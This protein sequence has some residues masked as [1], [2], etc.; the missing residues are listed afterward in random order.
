MDN[1]KI[2]E[3]GDKLNVNSPDI[4]SR[5]SQHWFKKHSFWMMHAT[6]FVLSGLMGLIFS[7]LLLNDPSMN[8]GSY[9]YIDDNKHK[10]TWG[11][12]SINLMNGIITI[13]Q[14]KYF[15]LGRM[16]RIGIVILNFIVSFAIS[17]FIFDSII[18]LLPP[19][20]IGISLLYGVYKSPAAK[21]IQNK[22]LEMKN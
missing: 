3:I 4:E 11:V 1:K 19:K 2:D 18:S 5:K 17:Q 21:N 15:N 16:I 12:L 6:N 8:A 22:K 7:L 10:T 20:P 14:K 9:P 13:P